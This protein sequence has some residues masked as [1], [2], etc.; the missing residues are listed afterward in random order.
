M[1]TRSHPR[2]R[3]RSETKQ[4]LTIAV[5]S[6]LLGGP[7][8]LLADQ[9]QSGQGMAQGSGAAEGKGV[10]AGA[11]EVSGSGT[12][13]YR[14]KDGKLQKRSGTGSV[15]GHGVAV[16]H[17][18]VEGSAAVYGKGQVEGT[19]TSKR[20]RNLEGKKVYQRR[21]RKRAQRHQHEQ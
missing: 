2:E 11:G 17:G 13:V 15:S 3:G 14:G 12:V 19:G 1:R 7:T 18:S 20:R 9:I 8:P 16:G 21:A 5:A 6:L 10:A 4:S